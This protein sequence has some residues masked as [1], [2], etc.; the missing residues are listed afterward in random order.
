MRF[1]PI[2][3]A[4]REKMRNFAPVQWNEGLEKAPHSFIK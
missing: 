2:Y 1:L 4:E 3:L